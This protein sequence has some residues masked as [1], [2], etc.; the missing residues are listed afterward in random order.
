MGDKVVT[1]LQVPFTG[2]GLYNGFRGNAFLKNRIKIFKQFVIPS[3]QAQTSNDFIL[4]CCWRSEEK[5]NKYVKELQAY[6][7]TIKEFKTIHT[8]NG[9]LF[10]DDKY[11]DDVARQ[12]LISNLHYSVGTMY[13]TIGDAD[14]VIVVLQP[15][16]DLYEKHAIETIQYLFETEDWQA[17]GFKNG[18]ICNYTTKEVAEYN[19]LNNPP[20]YSIKFTREQFTNP[21]KH[22]EHTSIKDDIMEV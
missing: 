22:I 19:P 14:Y 18:Y 13:D 2:L 3:L 12:R 15:S 9:I 20:F 17:V 16:D 6:L 10:Y 1:L 7:E 4:H 21:L 11:S 5:C 8:F